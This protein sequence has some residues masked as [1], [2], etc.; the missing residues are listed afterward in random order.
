MGV[1]W[2]NYICSGGGTGL[3]DPAV[4]LQLTTTLVAVLSI[5]ANHNVKQLG[6]RF[7]ARQTTKTII[8]PSK[9]AGH[10]SREHVLAQDT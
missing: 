8:S 4:A 2:G 1:C 6:A 7:L 3:A 9:V 5:K 10:L